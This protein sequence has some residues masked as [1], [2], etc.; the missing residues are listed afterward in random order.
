[1]WNTGCNN[2]GNGLD[3]GINILDAENQHLAITVTSKG[4]NDW[5]SVIF[6]WCSNTHEVHTKAFRVANIDSGRVFLY[7]FQDYHTNKACWSTDMADPWDSKLALRNGIQSDDEQQPLSA[8]DIMILPDR[9]VA[10]AAESENAVFQTVLTDAIGIAQAVGA[11]A[12]AAAAIAAAD[13][14]SKR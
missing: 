9:V 5:K 4:T 13:K 3:V 8:V 7:L 14:K 11:I 1:M 12:Q 10:L 2:I 6:P